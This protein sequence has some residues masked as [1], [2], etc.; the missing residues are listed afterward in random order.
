MN[1]NNL[2]N[3]IKCLFLPIYTASKCGHQTKL[4]GSTPRKTWCQMPL[5][6]NNS[7]RYCIECLEKQAVSCFYCGESIFVGEMISLISKD[8]EVKPDNKSPLLT[9]LVDKKPHEIKSYPG[10]SDCCEYMVL[11]A[12]LHPDNEACYFGSVIE[13]VMGNPNCSAVIIS[14]TSRPESTTTVI[15]LEAHD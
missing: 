6:E 4:F 8:K 9:V 2:W 12:Y 7:P 14:D 3:H 11:S 1:I 13:K 5:E 10:C 15:P